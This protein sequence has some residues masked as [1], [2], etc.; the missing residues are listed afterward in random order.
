MQ[1]VG[2]GSTLLSQNSAELL[3][4]ECVRVYTMTH[5]P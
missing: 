3:D 2:H 5:F 4:I 1:N